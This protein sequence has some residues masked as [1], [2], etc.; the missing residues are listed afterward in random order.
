MAAYGAARH[1]KSEIRKEMSLIAMAHRS[2]FV[3]QSTIAHVNHLLEGYIDGLNSRRPA[4][5]NIYAVCPPEHGVG[6]DRAMAQSK[7]AVESRAYPLFRYDPDAGVTFSE[8]ASIKGNPS[9]DSDWPSYVLKHVD[10]TGAKGKLH[11]HVTFADFAATEGRFSK[12][13][14]KAPPETWNDAMIPLAELLALPAN[15]RAGLFPYIWA[16]DTKDQL[17]RLIVAEELV[18]ASEERLQ[19]WRQLKDIVL[20]APVVDE[21]AIAE[22]VRADLVGRISASLGLKDVTPAAAPPK[23]APVAAP[24]EPKPAP[25]PAPAPTPPP[26][27]AAAAPAYEPCWVDTPECTAC[28]ECITTAPGAFA[29]NPAK[30]AVVTNPKGASFADLVMSAEKCTAGCVHPG[31]PWQDEP[32]LDKLRKRAAKFN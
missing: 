19:F 6:D 25:V 5:F 31:T 8:C 27:P 32:G 10:E 7:L 1:G 17:M 22:R 26:A 28:E 18:R 23:P 15:E 21:A 20:Q 2:A 11:T 29:Y 14:R 16:K 9:V 3:L 12:H 13:F 30:Q 4:L 24:P